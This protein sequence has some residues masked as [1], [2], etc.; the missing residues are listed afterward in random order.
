MCKKVQGIRQHLTTVRESPKIVTHSILDPQFY[1]YL[2]SPFLLNYSSGRNK[3]RVSRGYSYKNKR[4]QPCQL[5][6]DD[7]TTPARYSSCTAAVVRV[8]STSG[9]QQCESSSVH[10]FMMVSSHRTSQ[11]Q[12]I[13]STAPS[14]KGVWESILHRR[15]TA[16]HGCI[17]HR[18]A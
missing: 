10:L 2:G 4:H 9:W 7:G 6:C 5:V 12:S 18:V 15:Y 11:P 8:P 13:Q 16:M 17:H 14:V 3:R 1:G